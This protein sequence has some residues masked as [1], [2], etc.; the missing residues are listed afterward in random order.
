MNPGFSVNSGAVIALSGVYHLRTP[1]KDM[2]S[3]KSNKLRF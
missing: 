1:I 2:V 3:S